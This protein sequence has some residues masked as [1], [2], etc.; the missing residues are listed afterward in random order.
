[1]NKELEIYY[2]NLIEK[3]TGG[4]ISELFEELEWKLFIVGMY[5]LKYSLSN[6]IIHLI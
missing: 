6:R 5:R 2:T 1:M 3:K 4:Q